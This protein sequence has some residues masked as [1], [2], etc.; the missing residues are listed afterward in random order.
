MAFTRRSPT[1]EQVSLHGQAEAAAA[2]A[3]VPYS[4]FR[5]GA[6][7]ELADGTVVTGCNVENAAYS[8]AI[9]AERPAV[10]RAVAAGHDA[11][12]MR[13]IAVFVEGGEGP[14]CGA[15]RQVLV[16]FAPKAE[17]V[18]TTGGDLGVLLVEELL[19]AAFVPE[20]LNA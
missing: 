8:M 12:T 2:N 7:I 20:S 15:C 5:V 10:V 17:V 3:Y 18:F 1:T 16:E 13:S 19:P 14:P 11:R 6:A 4:G 9:C